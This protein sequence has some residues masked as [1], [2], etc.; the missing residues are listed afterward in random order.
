VSEI[1]RRC[2][3]CE[4]LVSADADWC[5]QCFADLRPPPAPAPPPPP[6]TKTIEPDEVAPDGDVEDEVARVGTRDATEPFWPCSVCGARNP[7]FLDVCATC[8]TPFAAVMRGVTRRGLDPDAA[9]TRSLVF[10]GSGHAMLGY[11]I[12]G[13]ARG[14][15]FV[16]ALGL[17]LF[18]SIT[19]PR[20]GPMLLAIVLTLGLAVAVYVLSAMEIK[21]LAA[22][23]R[24]IV[25]S[26]YLLWAS[27]GV[28]F[29]VVGAIALSVATS[30]R[31]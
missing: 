26:K 17:T 30:A 11:P 2:P 28:M 4:A 29:L 22:R 7:I 23:G 14:V 3:D 5:G 19:A 31:R 24:L 12:D 1:E 21:D 13:F 18:L 10:P 25:P 9:R 27:V 16:L 15:L 6:P 20:T 8:G